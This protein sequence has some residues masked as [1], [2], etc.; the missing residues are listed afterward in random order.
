MLKTK[1]NS[2]LLISILAIFSILSC[3]KK[4]SVNQKENVIKETL[5]L[6]QKL[7]KL[8]DTT[9]NY[10]KDKNIALILGYGFNDAETVSKIKQYLDS[11]FGV[12][13]NEQN[14]LVSI[15][16]FPKDFMS[17]KYEKI[18]L[19]ES[20]I[21]NKN[22]TG[23]II[24]GAP[25]KT[26]KVIANLKDSCENRLLP[27]PV[28]S[29]FPQDDIMGTQYTSDFVLDY[30]GNTAAT[31]VD[32]LD[33]EMS[34][35]IPDFDVSNLISNSIQLMISNK[36]PL[37][38]DSSLINQVQKLIGQNHKVSKFIDKETGLTSINHFNFE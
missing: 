19:L 14:A 21:E 6:P 4:E 31:N 24:L 7:R 33:N 20:K 15:F 32:S 11:M 1:K 17:G 10:L 2:L 30:A 29:F 8:D 22:L 18:D 23:M 16:V 9:M 37:K 34:F 13:T 26:H 27:Y 25:E 3:Q 36:Q 38:Q 35:S 5:N 28:F 12:E